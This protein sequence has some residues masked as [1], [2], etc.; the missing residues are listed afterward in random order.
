M[1]FVLLLFV[2]NLMNSILRF[3]PPPPLDDLFNIYGLKYHLHTEKF[4]FNIFSSNQLLPSQFFVTHVTWNS[5][6]PL[7]T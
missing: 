1:T 4:Q 7:Q 2:D 3:L 6:Q 5:L